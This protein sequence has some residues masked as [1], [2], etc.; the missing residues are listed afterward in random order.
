MNRNYGFINNYINN[1]FSVLTEVVQRRD[2]LPKIS[3]FNTHEF[4]TLCACKQVLIKLI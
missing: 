4:K 1:C 3:K 2:K